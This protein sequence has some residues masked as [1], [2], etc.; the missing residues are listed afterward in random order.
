MPK[1]TLDDIEYN[2]EDLTENGK[3]QLTSLQ[4]L[5]GQMQ[6]I[7]NEMAV[8]QTAQRTYVAALKAEIAQSGVQPVVKPAEA[9]E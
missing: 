8:Y 5:E 3:A 9:V 2:T 4:F 1:I 6:K 7:R